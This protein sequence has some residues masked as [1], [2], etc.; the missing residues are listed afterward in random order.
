MTF[1]AP[2]ESEPSDE[3][4]LAASAAR[5]PDPPA[6]SSKAASSSRRRLSLTPEAHAAA[7][8][9]AAAALDFDIEYDVDEFNP[10]PYD[11]E[12]ERDAEPERRRAKLDASFDAEDDAA[13]WAA[14]VS[15]RASPFEY[16]DA[17]MDA[18]DVGVT[19]YARRRGGVGGDDDDDG[20]VSIGDEKF[21]FDAILEGVG[22]ARAVGVVANPVASAARSGFD[23]TV[24]VLNASGGD[25]FREIPETDDD[26][27][28]YESSIGDAVAD[29]IADRLVRVATGPPAIPPG[30]EG[31]WVGT[32]LG[33]SMFHAHGLAVDDL[34]AG[35]VGNDEDEDDD[36][37]SAKRIVGGGAAAE[38]PPTRLR[39]RPRRDVAASGNGRS[40]QLYS[41]AGSGGLLYEVEDAAVLALR[42]LAATKAALRR[43]RLARFAAAAAAAAG[44]VVESHSRESHSIE[45]EPAAAAAATARVTELVFTTESVVVDRGA[46]ATHA[47]LGARTTTTS[48]AAT[49]RIVEIMCPNVSDVAH[50]AACVAKLVD[51][52]D[53]PELRRTSPE[54]RSSALTKLVK[55]PLTGEGRLAF[56]VDYDCRLEARAAAGGAAALRLASA[57]RLLPGR[58]DASSSHASRRVRRVVRHEREP[59]SRREALKK[60]LAKVK[61]DA[62]AAFAASE[63]NGRGGGGGASLVET[64]TAARGR[65]RE[66]EAASTPAP[67]SLG[68]STG[69]WS[70]ARKTSPPT[71]RRGAAVARASSRRASVASPSTRESIDDGEYGRA[72][73]S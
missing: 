21:A 30:A 33:L 11:P 38:A 40:A 15:A 5:T 64:E 43:G 9:A 59:G 7:A 23:S 16:D 66:R 3:E 32:T 58:A 46:A 26:G 37:A 52:A 19:L 35:A 61:R 56:V 14:S 8:A 65:R 49:C 51:R 31:T 57:A 6:S 69:G 24:I 48:R 60:K 22:D 1:E 36:E 29:A 54:W 45:G 44:R 68:R 53:E 18:G 50:L 27:T 20:V 70:S 28:F 41:S 72:G 25:R 12:P 39:V 4:E 71:S 2:E 63:R 62:A 17:G 34:L 73:I 42:D 67:T 13:A 47:A 55:G 10:H